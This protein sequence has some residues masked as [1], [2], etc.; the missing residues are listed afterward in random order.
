MIALIWL[1]RYSLVTLVAAAMSVVG[2]Q[3]LFHLS[4]LWQ[5]DNYSF[6]LILPSVL[7]WSYLVAIVRRVTAGGAAAVGFASPLIGGL[8]LGGPTG[9]GLVLSSWYTTFPTGVVTG[10][11]VHRCLQ[12]GNGAHPDVFGNRAEPKSTPT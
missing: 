3:L 5:F 11:L 2:C 6:G 12:V 8:L 7:L 10:L 1:V 9:L 4:A